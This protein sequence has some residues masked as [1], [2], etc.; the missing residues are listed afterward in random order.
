M[1]VVMLVF[2]CFSCYNGVFIVYCEGV[3]RRVREASVYRRFVRGVSSF[4]VFFDVFV[5][6]DI[7]FVFLCV[8]IVFFLFF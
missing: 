1:Y 6:F 8:L 5:F 4:V 7:F 2:I 3:F